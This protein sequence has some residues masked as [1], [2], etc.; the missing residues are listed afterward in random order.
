MAIRL[1]LDSL[2]ERRKVGDYLP[3]WYYGHSYYEHHAC[4]SVFH[5]IPLNY[6][7]R[8]SRRV[9][10]SWNHFRSKPS[11]EDDY[12]FGVAKHE[13]EKGFQHGRDNG[14][15]WGIKHTIALAGLDRNKLSNRLGT[16][17][18]AVEK[19]G[20]SH[21]REREESRDQT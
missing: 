14:M 11:P 10:I 12:I 15:E 19:R 21:A 3:P 2:S 16:A 1:R 8:A 13:F 18:R 7:I 5:P 4:Y 9:W 6:L 20:E 17:L